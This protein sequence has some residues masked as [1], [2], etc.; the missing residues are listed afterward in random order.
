MLVNQGFGGIIENFEIK[1]D[2]SRQTIKESKI[3]S[4]VREV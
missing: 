2:I 1:Y 4:N 3:K